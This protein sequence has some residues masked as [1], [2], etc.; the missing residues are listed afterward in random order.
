LTGIGIPFRTPPERLMRELRDVLDAA[1]SLRM[2]GES[3]VLATVMKVQGSTYRP[4][5]PGC[6]FRMQARSP[7][8]LAAVAWK[9][10]S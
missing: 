3:A 1:E 4:P 5:A 9:A 6:S 7:A 8:A 2:S 10:I